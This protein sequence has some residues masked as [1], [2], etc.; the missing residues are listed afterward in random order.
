VADQRA[1]FRIDVST[2]NGVRGTVTYRQDRRPRLDFRST[3]I[4]SVIVSGSHATIGG[5]GK[6]RGNRVAFTVNVDDLGPN[7]RDTFDI[8][9]S[10]GYSAGGELRSGRIDVAC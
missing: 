5:V 4:T 9:L 3:D 8:E 1:R 2:V 7:R 10:N 6:V